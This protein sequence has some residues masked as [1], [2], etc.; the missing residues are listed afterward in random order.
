VSALVVGG[1]TVK[2]NREGVTKTPVEVGEHGRAFDGSPISD[3]SDVFDELTVPTVPMAPAAATAL[4]NVLR[5][6]MPVACSGDLLGGAVDC[7]V[8][9]G[10]EIPVK[11]KDGP[12]WIINFTLRGGA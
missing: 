9:L 4:R 11:A 6:S 3:V 12:R 8:V 5:G 7:D 1:I 10:E 2:V